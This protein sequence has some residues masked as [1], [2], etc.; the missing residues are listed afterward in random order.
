MLWHHHCMASFGCPTG[1][2]QWEQ[3]TDKR[4]SLGS[5]VQAHPYFWKQLKLPSVPALSHVPLFL[6]VLLWILHF[7]ASVPINRVEGRRKG[8]SKV[9]L[10]CLW[11]WLSSP[12]RFQL[13]PEKPTSF[14]LH[15]DT[16][17]HGLRSYLLLVCPSACRWWGRWLCQALESLTIL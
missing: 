16:Q 15:S 10:F 4:N 6:S 8:D 5:S 3:G 7:Q 11:W 17:D 13:L 2:E 14:S 9:A 1:W 12:S